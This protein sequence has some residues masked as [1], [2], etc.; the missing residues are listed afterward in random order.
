M[1]QLEFFYFNY[2][3]ISS[4]LSVSGNEII[5]TSSS[6][7]SWFLSGI[8]PSLPWFRASQRRSSLFRPPTFYHADKKLS[9]LQHAPV[10]SWFFGF[11]LV[12]FGSMIFNKTKVSWCQNL[13]MLLTLDF[14]SS[15][16]CTYLF[17]INTM[18][19]FIESSRL[20]MFS[21]MKRYEKHCFCVSLT[22]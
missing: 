8:S 15:C 14:H 1:G 10:C 16:L 11:G 7:L 18:T 20:L 13:S 3:T 9:K 2:P 19:I 4:S 21:P 6:S 22:V 12:F 17:T 5:L